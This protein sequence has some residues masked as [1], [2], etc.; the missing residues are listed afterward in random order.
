VIPA[1]RLLGL[2]FADLTA[3]QAARAIAAR[4]EGAPFRYV[5]TPNAD[6]LVRLA[7]DAGLAPIYQDAWLAL[8][9]SRVV[10]G[11]GRRLGLPVPAVAPGSDVT[12]LLL[13]RY[14]RPNE[15]ITVIGMNARWLPDLVARYDLA[16]PAHFDPPMGFDR[17]P[18]AFADTV[19]FA[20]AHPA[21]LT[22]LAVGSPRQ[23]RIAAALAASGHASGTALCI[24]A[25]LDFLT[26]A[27]RRAPPWLRG[28]A[29][30]WAWRLAGD[31]KRMA[32]RYLLDSPRIIPLLL[33]ERGVTAPSVRKRDAQEP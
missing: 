26:G 29:L 10:A 2:N 19:A 31:P 16:P 33:R 3:E 25:S 23:E 11:L 22:F 8:L 21:R 1:V 7:S 17:D 30:E 4:P 12:E 24:G 20:L 6:H 27:A 13:D 18:V 15:R 5:V 9:D 32:R 14:V 28:L